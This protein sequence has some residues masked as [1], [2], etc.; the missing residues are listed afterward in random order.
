[1]KRALRI[2]FD[3]RNSAEMSQRLAGAKQ[4]MYL[5]RDEGVTAIGGEGGREGEREG[6]G[7]GGGGVT[8]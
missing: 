8:W 7:G 1:M 2:Y 4:L 3:N 5:K 6:R